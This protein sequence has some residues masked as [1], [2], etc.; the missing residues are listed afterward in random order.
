MQN[1]WYKS[2]DKFGKWLAKVL[3]R[4]RF[5]RTLTTNDPGSEKSLDCGATVSGFHST[6][7]SAEAKDLVDKMGKNTVLSTQT[8]DGK[9]VAAAFAGRTFTFGECTSAS[10]AKSRS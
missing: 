2:D 9:S 8:F 10:S 5:I 6:E 1:R 3:N 4:T 7:M